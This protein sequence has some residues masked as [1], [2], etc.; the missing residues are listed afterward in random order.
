MVVSVVV[1]LLF[2]GFPQRAEA[3][4][5]QT[6]GQKDAVK[7]KVL[8]IPAG[9]LVEARLMSK[10]RVRGRLIG[11]TEDGFTVQV[12]DGAANERTLSF[13][14]VRSFDQKDKPRSKARKILIGVCYGAAV[15]ALV[16]FVT[17]M[18]DNS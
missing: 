7:M 1:C 12:A 14:Q 17:M 9:S 4:A 3:G 5:P 15:G 2:A 13:D 18:A 6:L 11:T 16:F 10:E 8:R